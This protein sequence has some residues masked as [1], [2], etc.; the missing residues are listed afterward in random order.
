M[1]DFFDIDKFIAQLMDCKPLSEQE[2]KAL[3]DKVRWLISFM[4]NYSLSITY[5]E[6]VR[7]GMVW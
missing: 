2:V 3:C 6:W 4:G 5:M 1:T 7:W